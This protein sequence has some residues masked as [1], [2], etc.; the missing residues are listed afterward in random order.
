MYKNRK[1]EPAIQ[2]IIKDIWRYTK[3]SIILLD[4]SEHPRE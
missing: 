4:V 2:M 3:Y 1:E